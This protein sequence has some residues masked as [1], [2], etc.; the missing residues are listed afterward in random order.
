MTNT[1]TATYTKLRDGSWG[2]RAA[3]K[4]VAGQTIT[5]AKRDGSTKTETV[6]RVLWSGDGVTLASI[7]KRSPQQG[8]GRYNRPYG[9]AAPVAGYS[10][11]CTGRDGC[12]CFD[13]E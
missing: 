6:D 1:M 13:C 9:S 7:A 4:V 8:Y 12:R 10:R 11:H 3:G 5:V 2:V